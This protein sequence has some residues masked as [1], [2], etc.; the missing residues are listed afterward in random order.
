LNV[1]EMEGEAMDRAWPE[2]LE[3]PAMRQRA[4]A[5]V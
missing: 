3:R 1:F 5:F 4:I 2:R